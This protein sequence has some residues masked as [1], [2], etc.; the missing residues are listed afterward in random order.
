MRA[1]GLNA[2]MLKN[3]P[4]FIGLRYIRA[5]R[6]NQFIS[7]VS[8]FSLIGMALGVMSLI[9]VLSV[10]N[11]FDHEMKARLLKVIPHGFVN[12]SPGVKDW[13]VLHRTLLK[14]PKIHAAAPY[15]AGFG[16]LGYESV[17]AGVQLQGVLPEYQAEVSEISQSMILGSVES[18]HS[19]AFGIVIGA[20]LARKL[21]VVL[22][23][24]I[25]LTLP[26][27]SITLAG[28]YP[29]VKR[30]TVVGVF[31]VDSPIEQ[32]FAMIHMEDAARLWRRTQGPDGLQ[33]SVD[34]IYES[35]AVLA[36]VHN[37]LGNAF[38]VQDWSE[39]QGSLFQ[40]VKMEKLMIATLLSIIIAIAAFN[41]VSSLVLM[42]AD[43]RSDIA[44][45]RTLGLSV[46]QVMLIFIVQGFGVGVIG[47]IIGAAL[48]C[49]MANFIGPVVAFLESLVGH[50]VFDSSVYFISYLPSKLLWSD[51]VVICTTA[52]FLSFVAT[53]Y[54]AYRASKIEP[55]EALRYE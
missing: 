2:L 15:I 22:G 19:G 11:G 29:R 31:Q 7:F 37:D 28:A 23:D 42:V 32:E 9:L 10:M 41:I 6:R 26:E 52:L 1:L 21:G 38:Q 47:I 25:T 13:K 51:V 17:I 4:L 14:Y 20:L 24:R 49:V 8:G 12:Q 40:T 44:V 3:L 54:P 36:Q 39:T 46:R 33:I 45:L 30:F 18:L 5:K 53:L 50:Q 55:A 34:N 48:G 35:G 43:K 27:I 16:L